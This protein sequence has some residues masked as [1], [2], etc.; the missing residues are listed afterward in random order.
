M[1]KKMFPE[2]QSMHFATEILEALDWDQESAD[3][4]MTELSEY[5][6]NHTEN[7]GLEEVK[8]DLR[9]LFEKRI[10]DIIFKYMSF[11]TNAIIQENGDT[12]YEA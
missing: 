10:C 4:T 12:D 7:R 2:L 11:V 1:I 6:Q 5:L 9:L 3:K 8:Y